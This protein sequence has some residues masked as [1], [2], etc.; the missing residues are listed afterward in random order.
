MRTQNGYKMALK[1]GMCQDEYH[2]CP[3]LPFRSFLDPFQNHGNMEFFLQFSGKDE[4]LAK[5][6]SFYEICQYAQKTIFSSKY[7]KFVDFWFGWYV[8]TYKYNTRL[9]TVSFTC[10]YLRYMI[11]YNIYIKGTYMWMILYRV[12][13]ICIHT[14]TRTDTICIQDFKEDTG[15]LSGTQAAKGICTCPWKAGIL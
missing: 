6:R 9:D 11:H 14:T 5:R 13:Y 3:G 10:M 2:N 1:I 12:L 15:M 8:Y 7:C 4:F